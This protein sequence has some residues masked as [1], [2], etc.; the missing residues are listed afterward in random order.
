M[1]DVR[2]L[3][4]KLQDLY[5]YILVLKDLNFERDFLD[6]SSRIIA[7]E[8]EYIEKNKDFSIDLLNQIQK[9]IKFMNSFSEKMLVFLENE[10][11]RLIDKE[12]WESIRI[13]S[14]K[15]F[16]IPYNNFVNTLNEVL[17]LLNEDGFTLSQLTPLTDVEVSKHLQ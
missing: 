11:S 15:S 16:I 14:N 8:L 12:S 2:L 4:S 5:N 10:E 13:V 9:I 6:S 7:M 3:E 17:K 1:V